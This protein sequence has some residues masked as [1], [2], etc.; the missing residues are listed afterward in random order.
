M[1]APEPGDPVE[2]RLPG[3]GVV[4]HGRDG[5]IR[6]DEGMQQ[7]AE[8]DGDAGELRQC[9]DPGEFHQPGIAPRCADQRHHRLQAGDQEGQHQGEMAEFEDHGDALACCSGPGLAL[10]SLSVWPPLAARLQG[11]GDFRRHVF[12]VMLGQD[13]VRHEAAVGLQAAFH[14]HPLAL[15]EEIGQH[16]L[17]GDRQRFLQIGHAEARGPAV[18]ILTLP[19]STSPPSRTRPWRRAAHQSVGLKKKTMPLSR[20]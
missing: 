14:H 5:E 19:F 11:L 8:G 9:R 18:A 1:I 6:D 13:L 10:A 4:R 2:Q 20:L 16:A 3:M 17:I 12:L 15:A 7:G